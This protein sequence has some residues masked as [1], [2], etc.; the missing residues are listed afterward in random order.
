MRVDIDI[1]VLGY[2]GPATTALCL[3]F[4]A[5]D[6][7]PY[8]RLIFLRNGKDPALDQ[9]MAWLAERWTD[10][11]IQIRN[12]ENVGIYRGWNQALQ[13]ADAPWVCFL[14]SDCLLLPGWYRPVYQTLNSDPLFQNIGPVVTEGAFKLTDFFKMVQQRH[15]LKD[16]TFLPDIPPGACFIVRR[17]LFEEVGYFDERYFVTFG[18]TDWTQ[19][20]VDKG[21]RIGR[22]AESQAHHFGSVSR[23][24]NLSATTDTILEAWDYTVFAEQWKDRPD[25]LEKHP[26]MPWEILPIV[27]EQRWWALK[28]PQEPFDEE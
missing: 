24:T 1:I 7:P 2:G 28:E 19:R 13:Y 21:Y 15:P 4:L 3:S 16:I 25:V 10:R 9:V 26:P 11:I 5:S 17:D 12:D 22:I 8:P 20:L 27:K 18:Y 14:N 23:R 6:P